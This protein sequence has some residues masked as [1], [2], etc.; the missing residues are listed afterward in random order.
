MR[1]GFSLPGVMAITLLFFVLFLTF[2]RGLDSSRRRLMNHKYQQSAFWLATSGA[3]VVEARLRK[4]SMRVGEALISPSFR[5]GSFQVRT[6][7]GPGG[8][9]ILS[10]GNAGGQK[11]TFERRLSGL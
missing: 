4:G 3:D 1:R 9:L 8:I 7:L 6:S 10:T 2:Q 11:Y 5:N